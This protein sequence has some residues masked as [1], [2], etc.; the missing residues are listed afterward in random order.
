M[1]KALI[2]TYTPAGNFIT[3]VSY[4]SELW[5]KFRQTLSVMSSTDG[6]TAALNVPPSPATTDKVYCA[7]E[8]W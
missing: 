6:H 4:R 8:N 3:E 7:P 2:A 1:G 5:N